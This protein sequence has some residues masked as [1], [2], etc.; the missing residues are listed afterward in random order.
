[1][2]AAKTRPTGASVSAFLA[3]ACPGERLADAKATGKKAN[4]GKVPTIGKG[5]GSGSF[6]AQ[7]QLIG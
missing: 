3:K 4:E 1:M 7:P 2:A 6:S 5:G